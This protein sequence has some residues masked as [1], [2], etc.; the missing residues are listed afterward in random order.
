MQ[1]WH[2]GVFGTVYSSHGKRSRLSSRIAAVLQRSLERK[3]FLNQVQ[4]QKPKFS[5]GAEAYWQCVPGNRRRSYPDQSSRNIMAQCIGVSCGKSHA[6]ISM[7]EPVTPG[8][9]PIYS[10]VYSGPFQ[11][12]CKRDAGVTRTWHLMRE[13]CIT[14]PNLIIKKWHAEYLSHTHWPSEHVVAQC[15]SIR[16]QAAKGSETIQWNR[17]V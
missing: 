17:S 6:T 16:T 3:R 12:R 9:N 2:A 7:E 11:H 1:R 14:A 10:C 5:G 15:F 13:A 8:Q 4:F